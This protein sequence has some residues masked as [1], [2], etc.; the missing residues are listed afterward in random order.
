LRRRLRAAGE[1]D[2]AA[3]EQVRT[4]LREAV[5]ES[6][7]EIWLA[8]LELIALDLQGTLIVSAPP[9]T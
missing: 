1:E 8:R 5:G 7:F 6:V 3:W 2:L 4:I 9:E